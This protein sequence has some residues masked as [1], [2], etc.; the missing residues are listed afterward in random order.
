MTE[1]FQGAGRF[2]GAIKNV[3]EYFRTSLNI[4]GSQFN[5]YGELST[6]PGG[7]LGVLK[8]YGHAVI[9]SRDALII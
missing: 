1:N 6:F 8:T 4:F 9:I 3:S 2:Y 5:I 7:V